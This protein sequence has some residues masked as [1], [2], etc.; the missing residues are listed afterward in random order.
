M[1]RGAPNF[2]ALFP[3]VLAAVALPLAAT[4]F[5]DAGESAR[6]RAGGDL[7]RLEAGLRALA[8]SP[9]LTPDDRAGLER[10]I[11]E[12][13]SQFPGI[14]IHFDRTPQA[15]GQQNGPARLV[16]WAPAVAGAFTAELPQDRPSAAG[17]F[18]RLGLTVALLLGLGLGLAVWLGWWA[19][20]LCRA[21]AT[22]EAERDQALTRLDETERRRQALSQAG[23][24][25]LWRGDA[26]GRVLEAEGWAT[27]TGQAEAALRGDGWLDMLHPADQARTTHAWAG[28]RRSGEPIDI[29]FRLR[30][31][32][33]AW[34]WVRCRA[35]RAGSE[36]VGLVEDVHERRQAL[37]ELAERQEKL[38]L[39]V[40]A[41][42]LTSWEYDP[43]ADR[44]TRISRTDE[45]VDAPTA[46]SFT[47]TDW[48]DA[49]HPE[50]RMQ[51]LAR[52]QEVI[53]GEAGDF[54]AEFRVRR[55]LPAEGWSWVA[56]QG[57]VT[58]RDPVSGR[59]VR[60]SGISRD[61]SE[62]REAEQRRILLAREVDHRAKNVL[63]VV[64]SVLRLTR[65]DQPESYMAAVEAR[66]AALARA[67]TL[68]AEEGWVGADF[69]MLAERELA[70][71]P[72][73][74]TRLEGP[75]LAIAAGAV[76]P[77]AMVLHELATNAAR[78]GAA[79]VPEGRISLTWRLE[80]PAGPEQRLRLDW[81]ER[82]GPRVKEPGGR[83]GFGTRMLEAVLRGQ[84]GGA[85]ALHWP[86][87][88]LECRISLP[89]TRVVST[90]NLGPLRRAARAQAGPASP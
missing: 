79:S 35:V 62:R 81:I 53:A 71:C 59:V 83:R 52:L 51:V 49:V 85:L 23:S 89:A 24:L 15:A 75:P 78:H 20:R 61:V 21:H 22:V 26:E 14:A 3:V 45:A 69:G 13:A 28:A 33:G 18:G 64:Q 36:W 60:L 19:D 29:E 68:L 63:A 40:A 47:L 17:A 55:R 9:T 66:V 58:Q 1:N 46:P 65:R 37:T 87:E 30:T 27:L 56:S 84:L 39:A 10:G 16:V 88:G 86:P 48:V 44:G 32:A 41:A 6:L 50:D 42:R 74:S 5:W 90:E 72:P 11:Q 7:A 70:L 4:L 82:G 34:H 43:V 77:L 67:H 57:A 54:A 73:G 25:M 12:L 38:R 2:R 80:G 8:E 31:A 76:Q